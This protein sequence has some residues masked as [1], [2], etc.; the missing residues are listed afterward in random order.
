MKAL[1]PVSYL[2]KNKRR[3]LT[4][5]VLAAAAALICAVWYSPAAGLAFAA[6]FLLAGFLK[7][8]PKRPV[9]RFLMNALWAAA[10]IFLSCVLPT[11]VS[12]RAN[13]LDIGLFRL[14]M[15]YLCVAVVYGMCLAITG[16]I[17]S[18]VI[19]ASGALLI[20]TTINGFVYQFRGNLLKPTDIL[21][22]KT[23]LNVAGQYS[24]RIRE[25][26]AFSFLIWA[27]MLFFQS[28]LP[29]ED[30]IP[31]RWV[32][33]AAAAL[34]VACA[35]VFW[36]RAGSVKMLTWGNDGILYN[37]YCLNFAVGLR[38]FFIEAPEGYSGEGVEALENAYP[39]EAAVPEKRPNIL[40]IMNESF[41][42][43]SILGDGLRTNIP[44]TPFVDSLEENTIRGYALTSVF[45]GTTANAEFEFLTG[46]S[47]ANAPEG[48]PYQQYI[49][50]ELSSLVHLLN[51]WGYRT[52]ATHPYLSSGWNRVSAYTHLGFGEMTFLE[53]YPQQDLVREYVS[54]REMYA[55]ILD[56]LDSGTEQPLFLFGITMQNHGDYIYEGP[57]YEQTIFLEGYSQAYPMAEQ[58]LSLVH[59]SD[60]A[61]EYLLTELESYPEDTVVLFFGDHLPQIEGDFLDEVHGGPFETLEEQQL[62]YTVPF[63]LWANF[64]IPEQTVEC[65][66]LNYLGRYLLEAAGLELPPF[67]RFLKELEQTV[68]AVN[69]NGYYSSGAGTWLEL[70]EAQGEEAT[71]LERYSYLQYNS[72]F[73]KDGR[74]KHFFPAFRKRTDVIFQER[75]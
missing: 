20:L 74:S 31:R 57:N 60:E 46:L 28:G 23:A 17:K 13:Y 56:A 49:R 54:D 22:V 35:V 19:L 26:M 40:V 18:A 69:A 6:A 59:T 8:E 62:L 41:A 1:S 29:K 50:Q 65:T 3:L 14:V 34:T 30:W 48:C 73:D 5:V 45:G 24:F 70:D 55:Y 15:N 33:L 16:R 43:M 9:V 63:F 53:D 11:I 67:Y 25:G 64:D 52:F 58:Y 2:K 4:G 7:P 71:W 10:A 47:M 72:M 44:V 36:S 42:D 32:R 75:A 66:S 51:G 21:F 68:P 37:G 38:D 12:T 39:E 61:V 27:W